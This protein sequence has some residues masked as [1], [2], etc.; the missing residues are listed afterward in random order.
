MK[1]EKKAE[2]YRAFFEEAGLLGTL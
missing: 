1:L 2:Y